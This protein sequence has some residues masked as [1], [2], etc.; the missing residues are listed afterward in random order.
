MTP[1]S[2]TL[3]F[4]FTDIEGSTRL[5]EEQPEAMGAAHARHQQIIR[6]AVRAQEGTLVRERGEGDSTFSVFAS[7]SQAVSA[8]VALQRAL[9]TGPWPP[10]AA[11]RVRAALHTG[12][13]R[14][15]D[16]DYNS[17]SVNRCARLRAIAWGG[18]TLL[19]QATY[20]LVRDEPL[21]GARF[22]ELGLHGLKDLSRPERVFQLIHPELPRAFP[23]VR[24]LESV[25]NNLPQQLTSFVGREKEM[26]QVKGALSRA[27]LLTLTGTGGAGKTRLALQ[28]AADVLDDYP[29]G[30]WLMEL[31]SL[32]DS[33]LLPQTVASILHVREEPGRS[34]GEAL[35][36]FLKDRTVLLVLDNCEHL[37]DAGAR[38]ADDLLRSCPGVCILATSREAL[39]ITGEQTFR[40]P[41]LTA[42][43]ARQ[44]YTADGLTQYESVRLFIDRA[45]LSQP[46]FAVTNGNAP[47]VAQVCARLDGIPL[48][49]ELA[50]AR[51]KAL[52]VEQ[53]A[54]RLDDRFRLLTGGSRTALPRQQTLKA[55]IDWSYD[56]LSEDEK[57]LLRRLSVFA[58]GWTLEAA[59]AVCADPPE[60]A[61]SHSH[62]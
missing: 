43:D 25:P 14:I 55:A 26:A 12:Q 18:Q 36:G 24:S 13:A 53:I 3:T 58:G 16:D 48:A 28:S 34:A 32:A 21:E 17:S 11:L 60:S 22:Q 20:E 15:S 7:A 62:P 4:L 2:G 49:I 44:T 50:A 31:A 39:G 27:R 51:V 56:L 33:T 57:T 45:V 23:A 40:V 47:A 10:G 8:A 9:N 61:A 41:S 46:A 6:E 19:S 52:S 42:P 5:W 30:V 59:E 29:D 37:L 35:L 38:L 54:A 1:L